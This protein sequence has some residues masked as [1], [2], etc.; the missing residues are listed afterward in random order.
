MPVP[1]LFV[2]GLPAAFRGYYPGYSQELER[3]KDRFT[4]AILKAHTRNQGGTVRLR[5]ADPR[6]APEINFHYFEEGSD[7]SG[8]D[9]DAVVSGI[10]FVRTMMSEHI[11]IGATELL[12]G[13]DV[14]STE[15]LRRFVRDNA[16]GHHASC[17]CKLGRA[18]D[19]TAVVDSSF[20]VL[21][22]RNLRVVD[23]SVFPRIPGFFIVTPV[24]MISE[25]ASD[26]ILADA[27][28]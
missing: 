12:P 6:D 13:R 3:H 26:V 5:S 7:S 9:L 14:G 24:Y 25:K 21:G 17:S 20:R 1:D 28:S 8:E 10:E 16:W 11:D 4:W 15:D 18:D 2:F 23:A 19:E 27:R 22:T